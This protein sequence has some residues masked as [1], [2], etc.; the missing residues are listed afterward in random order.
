MIIHFVKEVF[1]NSTLLKLI[2]IEEMMHFDRFNIK[3]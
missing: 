1:L 2:N 3:D